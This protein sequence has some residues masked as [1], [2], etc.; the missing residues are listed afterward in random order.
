MNKSKRI[1]HIKPIF[2]SFIWGDEKL[3]DFF[4][5]ATDQ[6]KIGTIYHVIG[7]PNH[8]DNLVSETGT[9]I[10]EFYKDNPELFGSKKSYFPIRMTTTANSNFQSYQLHPDDK[11][12]FKHDNE[13]GKISGAVTLT[14]SD[15]VKNM[16][17]GNKAKSRAE[18]KKLIDEKDWEG[19]FS[20]IKVKD[21]QFLHTPAGV[22]HGG[23]GDGKITATFGTDGDLT[24]RFYDK[25]R[26]DPN[27][28][29]NI[30]AVVDCANIPEITNL[31]ATDPE[32]ERRDNIKIYNYYDVAKEYTA[33]RIKVK[34]ASFYQYPGFLFLSCVGGSGL[35]NS[36]SIKL[37][38]TLFI[39]RNYGKLKLE[40]DF[41][42]IMVSYRD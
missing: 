29:L 34:G 42:L 21:G 37:G 22:I 9:H 40:G 11:Y 2:K 10:S 4:K 20:K 31:R 23:Y 18:F 38:E 28:P 7:V 24:Y 14:E 6:K 16:L 5:L 27:R 41:D 36:I 17:F 19:L 15:D 35:I 1:Y 25:N 33:K 32:I 39:P 8:L 12:A 26:N 30:P 3:K 13:P